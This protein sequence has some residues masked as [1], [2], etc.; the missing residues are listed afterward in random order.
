MTRGR[1]F[2]RHVRWNEDPSAAVEAGMLNAAIPG[3]RGREA[4]RFL[5]FRSPDGVLAYFAEIAR[6]YGPIAQ[7][8]VL[9]QTIVLLDDAE[10]IGEVL[11]HQQHRFTRD[12][13]AALLREITGDGVL[14]L[15]D[16]AHV[17]RRRLLQPS[18][19]R[20][21]IERYT[22]HMVRET[23]RVAATWRAGATIDVGATMMRLTL[24]VVG[25]SLFGTEV[26][27]EAER[28]AAVVASIGRRGGR[29]QPILATISPLLLTLRHHLPQHVRLVFGRER[30]QLE[31][32]VDPIVALRRASGEDGDDLLSTLL[33]AQD[34]TGAALSDVDVRNELITFV[35]AGHETTSSALTWAWYL[36]ARSPRAEARL[37]AELDAVLG[38]R[39]AT[40]EDV[41]RLRYTANVFAEALRLYP[42][43]AAFA[44]RPITTVDVGEYRLPRGA[45]VFVSP[46]VTHRNPRY[47]ADPLA[48]R[49]E[50]W[51][52][53]PPPR[54]AFFP[55]GGGA[56]LC[57]GEAFART[58]GA[59][60]LATIARRWRLRV[61]DGEVS[62][63]P[64]ALLRPGR[65][66]LA[67]AEPRFA[68]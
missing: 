21:R 7:W 9:G 11:Q 31:R 3:P 34:E 13:G 47:F 28:I 38:E 46:F 22:E 25:A 23:Q 6:T 66:I 37:H 39:D 67:V 60:V 42:P 10:L 48:F 44:R 29:L 62:P 65:P 5:G 49:P 20:E 43:A 16:P 12:A 45:S 52:D 2:G 50:R 54:F 36:L 55:F 58:E 32:V 51:D 33:A 68:A 27:P 56:K 17:R 64:S 8:R 63:A 14:T 30:A 18:F 59:L 61:P 57:I 35:L 53:T 4:L 19:H 40:I 24:A 26:G 15:D 1:S 41:P